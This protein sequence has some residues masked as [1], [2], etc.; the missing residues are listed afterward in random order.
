MVKKPKKS[1]NSGLSDPI[2]EL[3]CIRMPDKGANNGQYCVSIPLKYMVK[4]YEVP[5]AFF[6]FRFIGMKG[7]LR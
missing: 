2:P 7:E 4:A 3:K 6:E 5:A 1:L